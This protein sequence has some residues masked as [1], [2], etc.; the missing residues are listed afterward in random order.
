MESHRCEHHSA[1]SPEGIRGVLEGMT[2]IPYRCEHD[3]AIPLQCLSSKLQGCPI[4][5]HGCQ[6]LLAVTLPGSRPHPPATEL[7]MTFEPPSAYES[8]LLQS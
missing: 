1:V 6:H 2:M 3:L 8:F 4:T 5:L 7:A